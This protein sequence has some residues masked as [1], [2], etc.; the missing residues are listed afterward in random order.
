MKQD[1]KQ[2]EEEGVLLAVRMQQRKKLSY[3]QKVAQCK[4]SKRMLVTANGTEAEELT[5]GSGRIRTTLKTYRYEGD[6]KQSAVLACEITS[7]RVLQKDYRCF[8]HQR[9][10]LCQEMIQI[11]PFFTE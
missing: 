8:Q 11:R 4:I 3:K 5:S 9:T 7:P 6:F 10:I 2:G 1:V